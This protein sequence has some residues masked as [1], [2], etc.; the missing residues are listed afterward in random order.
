MNNLVL[1]S[2]LLFILLGAAAINGQDYIIYCK[3]DIRTFLC[4]DIVLKDDRVR[5]TNHEDKVESELSFDDIYSINFYDD[6]PD[7]I[8]LPSF[9]FD[10]IQCIIDSISGSKIYYPQENNLLQSIDKVNVFCIRS[11]EL[12]YIPE[13][14]SYRNTF[15]QLHK[16]GLI[17]A[18]RIIKK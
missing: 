1:K 3:Y 2:T 8:L 12:R 6:K 5:F 15:F 7:E 16:E 13:I 14:N 10:T 17:N 11:G 4:R 18:S 9:Q